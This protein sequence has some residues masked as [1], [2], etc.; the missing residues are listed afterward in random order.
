MPKLKLLSL[1]SNNLANLINLEQ[2]EIPRLETL[3]C[4]YN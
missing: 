4:D 2:S 3:E 1:S